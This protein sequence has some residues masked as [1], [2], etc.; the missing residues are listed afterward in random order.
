[1][2][3]IPETA[4]TPRLLG[5]ASLIALA[6]VLALSYGLSAGLGTS[7]AVFHP[8]VLAIMCL[9][10]L[11]PTSRRAAAMVQSIIAIYIFCLPINYLTRQYVVGP[12]VRVS[13][14]LL[15][16]AACGAVFLLNRL[17][18]GR[19]QEPQ[20]TGVNIAGAATIVLLVV[21]LVPLGILLY[22]LYGFGYERDG[23]ILGQLATVLLT[24]RLT[25]DTMKLP[26]ARVFTGLGGLVYC[27]WIAIH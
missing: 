17:G 14:S 13:V 7:V 5:S 10:P 15:V 24:C 21:H 22:C 6:V 20:A 12:G 26:A 25:W 19:S 9:V 3:R 11:V 8:G 18:Q 16:L 4:I 2:N 27:T 23:T 1:M